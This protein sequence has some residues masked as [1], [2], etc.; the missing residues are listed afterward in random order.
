MVFDYGIYIRF[1]F[2][3]VMFG[4]SW[5]KF[6]DFMLFVKEKV[7]KIKLK[8]NFFSIIIKIKSL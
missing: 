5:W 3:K 6:G 8:G 2:N 4:W 1:F 7:L